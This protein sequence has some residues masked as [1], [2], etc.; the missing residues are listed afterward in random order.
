LP[1]KKSLGDLAFGQNI[2]TI[3]EM[4]VFNNSS[5]YLKNQGTIE[6]VSADQ[7]TYTV[8]FLDDICIAETQGF[9]TIIFEKS[10]L[11]RIYTLSG[12]MREE[13]KKGLRTIF[14]FPLNSGK[15]RNYSGF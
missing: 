4:W 11:H 9:E 2:K 1:S 15:Q 3:G 14:N 6:V 7:N 8:K 10:T 13:Y 12:N 5:P